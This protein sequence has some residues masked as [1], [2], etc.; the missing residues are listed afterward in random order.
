MIFKRAKTIFDNNFYKKE[1]FASDFFY[2]PDGDG[3]Y[4]KHHCK[5]TF[6]LAKPFIKNYRNAID[7]GCR[8]GEFTRFLQNF[9][10]HTFVLTPGLLVGSLEM[11][12]WKKFLILNAR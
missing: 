9:F 1:F 2:S 4:P 11:L 3:I 5:V 12:I 8:D 6:N 7:I 10:Q